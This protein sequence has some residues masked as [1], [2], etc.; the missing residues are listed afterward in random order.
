MIILGRIPFAHWL[1][2]GDDAAAIVGV[3]AGETLARLALLLL[4][5]REDGGAILGSDVIALAVELGR[6]VSREEDVEQIVVAQLFGIE[7]DA[8]RFGMAGVAAAHLAIG[9]VGDVPA[10]IAAFDLVDP[11]NVEEHG[12]GAPEAP[13]GKHC[14]FLGHRPLLFSQADEIVTVT[15]FGK[16]P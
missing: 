12:F 13:A 10:G 9:R 7:G 3:G 11:D 15:A 2:G 14:D 8:D 6:V 16:T 1:D 5:L 4:V